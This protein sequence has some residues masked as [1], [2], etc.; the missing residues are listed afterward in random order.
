MTSNSTLWVEPK[1]LALDSAEHLILL[2]LNPQLLLVVVLLV[3]M[4]NRNTQTLTLGH[5]PTMSFSPLMSSNSPCMLNPAA[6]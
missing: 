5:S 2:G 3:V 4:L 6:P 1:M